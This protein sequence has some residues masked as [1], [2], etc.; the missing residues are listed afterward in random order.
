MVIQEAGGRCAPGLDRPNS[1]P[2]SF[3][4][5]P[6]SLSKLPLLVYVGISACVREQ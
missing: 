6:L 2:S 4:F 3:Q 5:Q 1:N